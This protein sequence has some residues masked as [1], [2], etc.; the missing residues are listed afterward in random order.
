MTTHYLTRAREEWERDGDYPQ[1][2][3]RALAGTGWSMTSS[4]LALVVGFSAYQA[5]PF[6]SF[7]DTGLLASWTLLVALAANL[8]LTPVLVLWF[9]PFGTVLPRRIETT[10]H[11]ARRVS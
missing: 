2:L 4:T 1:A 5:V 8:F 11:P 3:R 6:Q 9:R 7:R 10:A